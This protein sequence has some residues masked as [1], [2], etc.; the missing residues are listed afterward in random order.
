MLVILPNL[1]VAR[2]VIV[3]QLSERKHLIAVRVVLMDL[4]SMRFETV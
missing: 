1:L 2:V 4:N 3:I